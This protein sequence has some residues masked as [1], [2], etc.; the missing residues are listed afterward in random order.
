MQRPDPPAARIE[1]LEARAAALVEYGNSLPDGVTTEAFA[2]ASLLRDEARKLRAANQGS[3]R[4]LGLGASEAKDSSSAA[5]ARA[6]GPEARANTLAA[7]LQPFAKP[8]ATRRYPTG[9]DE[10]DQDV[11]EVEVTVADWWRAL[12]ALGLF[13]AD[14]AEEYATAGHGTLSEGLADEL[15]SIA[16]AV[17]SVR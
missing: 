7:V 10:V 9:Q 14:L 11:L 16:R 17:H 6:S 2:E 5:T 12:T 1:E 8:R 4:N 15:R 3:D 13:D